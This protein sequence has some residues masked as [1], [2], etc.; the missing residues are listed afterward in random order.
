MAHYTCAKSVASTTCSGRRRRRRVRLDIGNNY[1]PGAYETLAGSVVNT[2]IEQPE[3]GTDRGKLFTVW[4]TSISTLMIT[5]TSYNRDITVS[6]SL[7]CTNASMLY[8]MC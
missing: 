4:R 6:V 7:Y 3:E 5:S 2:E 1:N 8:E